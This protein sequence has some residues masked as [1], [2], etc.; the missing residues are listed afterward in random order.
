MSRIGSSSS[1]SSNQVLSV[2]ELRAFFE[3]NGLTFGRKP[4]PHTHTPSILRLVNVFS[5]PIPILVQ[6]GLIA[7]FLH[8]GIHVRSFARAHAETVP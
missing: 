1:V 8:S 5:L 3:G 6:D 2:D 4:G 7:Q